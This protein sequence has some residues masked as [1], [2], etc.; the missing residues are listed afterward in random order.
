M[1]A[2]YNIIKKN[3]A[4]FAAGA[5]WTTKSPLKKNEGFTDARFGPEIDTLKM[6]LG[7]LPQGGP[8]PVIS[9]SYNPSYL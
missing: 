1:A 2:F 3:Q 8:V 7:K 4:T 6:F 9:K 5:F